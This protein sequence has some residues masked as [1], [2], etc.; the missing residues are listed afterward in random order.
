MTVAGRRAATRWS[1]TA[2]WSS[3]RTTGAWTSWH[4]RM[5]QPMAT[6]LA[7]F[8]AGRFRVE[9][10]SATGC[11]TVAVSTWFG[12]QGAGPAAAADAGPAGDRA[13]AGDPVRP[14]PVRLHRRRRHLARAPASRSRTRR[15]PTYPFLGNGHE[16]H[17]TVVHELAHQWFGD[18]VSGPAVA[19]H[20]AQRGL[21]DLGG[22]ALRRDPRPRPA[23]PPGCSGSTPRTRP[24]TRSGGCAIADPGAERIFDAP[25][26]DR[27]AMTL[28]ALRN[29][30]GR[31]TCCASA[32]HLG[33]RALRRHRHGRG[34]RGARRAGQRAGPGRVLRRLAAHRPAPGAHRRQ[35]PGLSG[36]WPGAGPVSKMGAWPTTA[37][38]TPGASRTP[39]ASGASRPGSSTGSRSRSR[40][41]TTSTRRSTGGSPTRR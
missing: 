28:Q 9:Q 2:R 11:R 1:A 37:A 13:L 8:A 30:I 10:G 15:R 19:R 12:Q 34:V 25:V 17:S 23:R 39:R 38:S 31:R 16:A 14:L 3:R 4:W 32:A 35:R 26:Y 6:Y 40:C 36:P 20:L 41:S 29:R 7:F 21:R 22:V 24:R 33:A 27:G 18:D 5:R